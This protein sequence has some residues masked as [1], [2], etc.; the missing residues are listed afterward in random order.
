MYPFDQ[1]KKEITIELQKV[2]AKYHSNIEIRVEIPPNNMGDFAFPCFSLA[3]YAKKSPIDLA[4]DIASG[5]SKNKLI[6]KIDAKGG[7]VNFFIDNTYLTSVT[8]KSILEKKD[9]YGCLQ[10]KKKKV[11]IEHTSANPNGPLHVGR[12]RNPIIGDTLVRIFKAAGYDVE[13]QFYLDDMG[14]QVAILAWGIH[15][16]DGK[17]IPLS[18]NKK[19]DHQKVG[20]YQIANE[21]MESDEKVTEAIGEIVK[22][23]EQGDHN[24]IDMI[25]AS[26]APVLDGIK[27]SLSRINIHIDTYIPESAFI[28]DKSVDRV[29]NELKQTTYCH[30]QDAAFYLDMEP[31]GIHGRST[32]FFFLRSDGTTLYATRDIAYHQWKAHHADLLINVLGEDHKLE[33]KQVQV[34]LELLHTKVLPQIVFYAFVSLPEGKMS[35]RRGRVVYLDELID[36]CIER[37]YEEVKKR[38][39]SELTESQMKKIA[40]LV[41]IGCLRYNIIKIQPEKDILFTWE[42]ALNFEGNAIPFIQYAHARACSILSK[43]KVKKYTYDSTLLT[44]NSE[45]LLVKQLAR[46]PLVIDDACIG[47]KPHIVANYLYETA[48]VFN[49]FYRD[50]PVLSEENIILRSSRIALVNATK[51][52]LHN[53]LDLLGISAPEEM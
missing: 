26:Y 39:A 16:L 4:K 12:A 48:S 20:F 44:H 37:A 8:L 5:I 38:R 19:A 50:C 53:A 47:C 11:I 18:E 35:T 30:E 40:E 27:Q 46:F 25:H 7:Y 29:I 24:T 49:Q 52:V 23:L 45:I 42:E 22:K 34:A 6:T 36:E 21:R 33:S 17:Q 32:K 10:K 51:I 3:P 1:C 31:F 14:K 9:T 15:N 43:T 13:S 28:N 41:G 2:L